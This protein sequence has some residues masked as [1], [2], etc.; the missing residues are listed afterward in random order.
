MRKFGLVGAA[1]LATAAAACS[2][3]SSDNVMAPEA[4]ALDPADVNAA[5]GPEITTPET[6]M[7]AN[8]VNSD[9]NDSSGPDDTTANNSSDEEPDQ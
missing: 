6:N 1:A 2:Q 8:D 3:S 7:T 5:L 4:N 9:A